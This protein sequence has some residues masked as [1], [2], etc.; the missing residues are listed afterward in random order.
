VLLKYSFV[1]QEHG[2]EE[3]ARVHMAEA[4]KIRPELS[5]EM[6]RMASIQ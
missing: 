5:L 3:K 4:L 2:K 6:M 1:Y